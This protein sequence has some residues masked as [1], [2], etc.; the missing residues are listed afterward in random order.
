MHSQRALVSLAAAMLCAV[1]APSRAQVTTATLYGIVQ[2][3]T[4]GLVSGASVL[5]T[6]AGTSAERRATSD[7]RGEF[8]FTVLPVGSYTLKIEKPGFKAYARTGLA[9]AASQSVR[10]THTLEVGALAEEISVEAFSPLVNTV[11]AEQRETLSSQQVSELPLSRRNVTNVLRLSSGV[12]VGGGSVRINGQG[13]SGATITVDGTDANANPS[14]GRSMEQYGGRNYIDVMSVEAVEEVQLMRGILQA[15]YGGAVSGQVN[16]IAKSGTNNWKGSAFE[17]YRSHV[18]NARNPFQ[19]NRRA[20]GSLLP[21]NR[22]VF[23]QFGGS[24]GGPVLRDRLFLFVTYE[25][26]RE[27]AFQRVNGDVPTPQLRQQILQALPF[28]ETRLLL[29]TLPEPNVPIDANIGR[30]EGTGQRERTENHF[31]VKTDF[32]PSQGSRFSVAY[33]RN[34]PFGLDPRYNLEGANDR[35]YDYAQDRMTAQYTRSRGRWV[36]ETR[37]GYNRSDM[38]RLDLFFSLKDPSKEETV[39]WQRRVPRLSIQG[40]GTWGSAEVWDMQGATYSF[41]QKV[42]REAGRHL[43]KFGGRFFYN[44]GSRTNPENP[45]YQFVNLADLAANIPGTANITFGSHGPHKSRMFEFG[46]FAQDDFRVS[47]RLVLNLGLRYDFYSNN[48]VK[49]TGDVPVGIVNLSPASDLRKFDFGPARPLDRPTEHDG[50]VNLGPRLGFAFNPDARG[51]TVVRGGFGIMYAGQVPALLRQSVGHP[52]VPFRTIYTRAETQRLGIR[53]PMYAEDIRP[54]AEADVA[55]SGRRLVFSVI[56]PELQNPYTMNFQLNVQRSLWRDL[57]FEV[58]YVGV[59]GMKYP[60]HRRFNLPDRVS[61]ER[62]NPLLIPGGHYVDNSE[63]TT[64]HSLQTSVR[65]RF[66]NSFSFDA[67][68]T[69]GRAL[70][71]TGGDV[72]VYY[73]T[74]V[75][76]NV[77]QDFFDLSSERQP[78]T[79]DVRHRFVGDVI[80]QAPALKTWSSPL[81]HVFGGWQ[82]AGIVTARSGSPV[83]I[84][85]S[86]S[87]SYH[88][89]PDHLGGDPVFKDLKN[90]EITTGCRPGAHCD[91]QYLDRSVFALVPA[92]RGVALRPG[93]ASKRLVRGLGAWSV[94]MSLAKNIQVRGQVKLQLRADVFNA[95]NHLNLNNPNGNLSSSQFGRITGAG[96]MRSMQV[97]VRMQF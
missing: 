62:P 59:R 47:S 28:Q 71:Y 5:L 32:Q 50:W 77:V 64:Y 60:M 26:Y 52:V 9:L 48:V 24:L 13:K 76:E 1:A 46:F 17:N 82:V 89:R 4:G 8:V 81:R 6:H 12:D 72:G 18:F 91:V 88:C 19:A 78:S 95:L 69:Y 42:S 2:D 37:F 49:P 97:G 75:A 44:T 68:Y 94:D 10:Q 27:S 45:S 40:I 3:G 14:E 79:G 84:T 85:Q 35:T 57:M 11:S 65:K 51:T 20:D 15:E 92:S 96:G 80:Y 33:T 86:C 16:L 73:G 29:N 54:I 56:D 25:G 70:S 87:S 67:H 30:F 53:Y 7:E 21:K 34:R 93:T 90:R 23:N 74:D 31:V 66:S 41:D 63:S 22:E 38:E 83:F 39:E 58:G 61:G 55:A 43:L 36:S